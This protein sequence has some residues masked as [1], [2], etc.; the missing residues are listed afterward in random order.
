M[1]GMNLP[2]Q[3]WI[4]SRYLESV[5]FLIAPLLLSNSRL[6]NL[7]TD[8]SPVEKARFAWE[9]FIVYSGIT[10]VLFLSIFVLRNF[11]DSYIEGRGLTD[12]LI[13]SEYVISLILVCSLVLLYLK[14]DRF[15]NH[16][17]RLLTASIVLT[18]IS[19]II[20]ARFTY[21]DDFRLLPGTILNYCL[22]T[23]FTGQ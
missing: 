1:V 12:F 6:L 3:L 22:S 2:A 19:E 18:I 7:K 5:S 14:R 23:L 16:V 10:F 11:P 8:I 4:A 17:F 21:V 9:L 15:E 20:F 13:I